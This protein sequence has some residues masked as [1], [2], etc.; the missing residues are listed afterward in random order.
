M[1]LAVGIDV[2]KQIHWAEIKVAEA[3]K[4]LVN[5]RVDN[6]PDAI[7][8]LI[9]DIQ[10]AEAEHGRATVGIDILGGIAALLQAMLLAAGLTVVHVPGLAVNRARQGTRGGE[11]KS[12]PKDARVIADQVRIRDDL[13]PVTTGRDIDAELRLLVAR[14]ADLVTD[15][16]RRA[17]RL[18]ELLAS[19]HPGLERQLDLT[20]KTGLHLLTQYVTPAEIR[21]AGRAR[22]L[23]HLRKLS[24]VK[25]A[26]LI[27]LADGTFTSA[28]AQRVSVPGEAVAADLVRDIAAEALAARDRLAALDKRLRE[29]LERHPDAAL[30]A[31]LPGMG[32][33]LTAEFLAVTGGIDRYAGGDQLAAAA[34]L[35]PVLRQSGKV[36]YLQRSRAG[37]KALKRVFYQSAFI[38]VGCDPA[39]K[40]FYRRKKDQGKTHH[41]AVLALARRRV[42]VLHAVL[43][44]RT[45]YNPG[46]TAVAA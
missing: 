11:H 8:N 6:T 40:A 1:P 42:N 37:D 34:G 4:V 44:N 12:D 41:Q 2:A 16:T 9:A 36:R 46:H 13:R 45:P 20:G 38:A 31:S 19:I 23:A 18:R 10:A 32:A 30:I 33:V 21:A 5:R 39:S 29:V 27:A 14:R 22:V 15:A 25:D 43:R 28:T 24:H 3:G 35:A 7:E 26:Q 17:N